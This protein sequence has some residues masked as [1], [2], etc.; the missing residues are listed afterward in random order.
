MEDSQLADGNQ[1][2]RFA[3]ALQVRDI[4]QGLAF[5][6][7]RVEH[8]AHRVQRTLS[9]KVSQVGRNS[10]VDRHGF[11]RA[12]VEG[13]IAFHIEEL[14]NPDQHVVCRG[15]DAPAVKIQGLGGVR[16]GGNDV[17]VSQR[18]EVHHRQWPAGS[19]PA[20][21]VQLH[22]DIGTLEHEDLGADKLEFIRACPQ[23]DVPGFVLHIGRS[24][25]GEREVQVGDGQA[26]GILVGG[27]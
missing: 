10:G 15:M 21:Q 9:G 23:R 20:R 25:E 5:V 3:R 1:P 24:E 16:A 17:G 22:I 4:E 11:P 13:H 18:E 12:E 27:F 2:I 14:G 19:F 7:E 6:R 8:V 26:D